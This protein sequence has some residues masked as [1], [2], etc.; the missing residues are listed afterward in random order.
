MTLAEAMRKGIRG[1]FAKALITL[2]DSPTLENLVAA[3]ALADSSNRNALEAALPGT[4]YMY[5]TW[6][7]TEW[8]SVKHTLAA[9]WAEDTPTHTV[10][11]ALKLVFPGLNSLGSEDYMFTPISH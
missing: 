9:E 10:Q 5:R 8:S 3:Y 7:N 11:A 4:D 1:G 2:Y 6:L